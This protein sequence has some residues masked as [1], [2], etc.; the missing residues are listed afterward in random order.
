MFV[1]V[2]VVVVAIRPVPTIRGPPALVVRSIVVVPIDLQNLLP[3][4]VV[5]VVPYYYYL[6]TT[7]TSSETTTRNTVPLWTTT[8]VLVRLKLSHKEMMR[9]G[10]CW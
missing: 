6:T 2:V 4:A 8:S 5:V 10:V 3:V 9:V 1:V 7:S